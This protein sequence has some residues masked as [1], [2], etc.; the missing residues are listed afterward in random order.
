VGLQVG[1][2]SALSGSKEQGG[3][4]QMFASAAYRVRRQ[5]NR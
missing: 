1:S 3:P 2:K 5:L 4:P